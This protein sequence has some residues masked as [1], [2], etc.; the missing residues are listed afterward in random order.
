M[1]NIVSNGS[2]SSNIYV[3]SCFFLKRKRKK[4]EENKN[5]ITNRGG[6]QPKKV[7]AVFSDEISQYR[8]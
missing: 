1:A 3:C 5:K 8:Q 7:Y 4:G 6:E 2:I